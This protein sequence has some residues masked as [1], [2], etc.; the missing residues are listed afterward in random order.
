M[1]VVLP[2]AKKKSR[3]WLRNFLCMRAPSGVFPLPVALWLTFPDLGILTSEQLGAARAFIL[4]RVKPGYFHEKEMWMVSGLSILMM[5]TRLWNAW[6]QN[7]VWL[8]LTMWLHYLR[9]YS[10]AI[11]NDDV[12]LE[13]QMPSPPVVPATTYSFLAIARSRKK[14]MIFRYGVLFMCYEMLRTTPAPLCLGEL[15]SRQSFRDCI[16]VLSSPLLLGEEGE[17]MTRLEA[18]TQLLRSQGANV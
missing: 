15:D 9:W 17:E 16:Y 10:S 6:F 5:V 13:E 8:T 3:R 4:D 7:L 12:S 1:S 18:S 2:I 11:V 14:V